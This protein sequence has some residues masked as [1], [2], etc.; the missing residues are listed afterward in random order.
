MK[1]V[2]LF[3]GTFDPPHIG[4]LQIAEAVLACLQLDEIWFI[5]T[6]HPPHKDDAETDSF[7][8]LQMVKLMIE[9]EEKFMI[10][11]IELDRKGKSYTIDTVSQLEQEYPKTKFYFIIGGD[12]VTYLK[13]WKQIDQLIEKVQFVGVERPGVNWEEVPYVEKL[14]IPIMDVSSTEIREQIK[15]GMP[16]KQYVHEKVYAYIKEHELYG[17]RKSDRT[18]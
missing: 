4:H 18:R 14:S 1:R 17:F 13:H 16:F 6:Y 8:R 7:H 9:H 11:T 3:G 10:N 2:G 15:A 12:Q 5:P